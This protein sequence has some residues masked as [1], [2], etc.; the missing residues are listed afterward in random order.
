MPAAVHEGLLWHDNDRRELLFEIE[1]SVTLKK[2][3][4][5]FVNFLK[6]FSLFVG[7]FGWVTFDPFYHLTK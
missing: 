6:K 7:F 4:T 3:E 1:I 2:C 5:A